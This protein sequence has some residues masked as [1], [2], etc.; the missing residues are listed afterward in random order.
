MGLRIDALHLSLIME[1]RA[2]ELALA[3]PDL[4]TYTSGR[5]DAQAQAHA[6]A[7]NHLQDP[8]SY[9][10]RQYVHGGEFLV[11]L[12]DNPAADSVDEV[13]EVFYE[14]LL[15]RPELI[16]SPHLTGDAV[17]RRPLEQADGQPTGQGILVI[18]WIRRCPDTVDFRTREG[19]LRRWHWACRAVERS[20]EV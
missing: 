7:V 11:Q 6:M 13:T 8:R 2:R 4:I 17:D 12:R 1:R 16:R 19:S 20:M 3:F 9:L 5:R 15:A 18:Q 10:L 14:T